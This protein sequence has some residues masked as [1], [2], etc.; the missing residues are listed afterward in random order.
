MRG[1]EADAWLG[2]FVFG[3]VASDWPGRAPNSPE[4]IF[5]QLAQVLA[6]LHPNTGGPWLPPPRLAVCNLPNE[7]SGKGL[8]SSATLQPPAPARKAAARRVSVRAC[9]QG[10]GS[11]RPGFFPPKC[12]L[13]RLGAGM[14]GIR[15]PVP[16]LVC[17]GAVVR[18]GGPQA[19]GGSVGSLPA[20]SWADGRLVC[21][22]EKFDVSPHP[23][24][25]CLVLFEPRLP[26]LTSAC[27]VS[28][29]CQG[30]SEGGL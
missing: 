4:S 28:Q 26:A 13:T 10:D 21:V 14:A 22:A 29:V 19:R 20:R 3:K 23:P 6:K 24:S 5:I 9:L 25:V 17:A 7:I 11:G 27:C 8:F 15:E 1:G 12:Y 2:C 18:G 30:L 16:A